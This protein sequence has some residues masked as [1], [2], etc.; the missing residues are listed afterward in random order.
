MLDRLVRALYGEDASDV[1]A[2]KMAARYSAERACLLDTA[3]HAIREAEAIL[4]IDSPSFTLRSL[5]PPRRQLEPV[6]K[7]AEW[8]TPLSGIPGSGPLFGGL[9]AGIGD[10]D[11]VS[12]LGTGFG[13]LLGQSAGGA[14]G[15]M[16][17]P[18][19]GRAIA[20]LVGEKPQAGEEWGRA[21][22]MLGGTALGGA[23]GG[24]VGR[25]QTRP[26]ATTPQMQP[27]APQ[28]Q[29]RQAEYKLARIHGSDLLSAIPGG[30]SLLG[31]VS[32]G[33]Q[34]GA[35][36]GFGTFGGS[37]LGQ[38]LGLVGGATL[39]HALGGTAGGSLGALA[40]TMAGGGFGGHYGRKWTQGPMAN[41]R[42]VIHDKLSSEKRA[43]PMLSL[44]S[45][46][47]APAAIGA[48]GAYAASPQDP[49]A[50]MRN[51]LTGAGLGGG[52]GLLHALHKS[53]S[54]NPELASRL[55]QGL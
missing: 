36:P 31:G 23:L 39:G 1:L 5:P 26:Q 29:E 13:S 34:D 6:E 19:A 38:G 46:A 4:G 53:F 11:A 37:L 20:K 45:R 47:V 21:L 8:S 35:K 51:S 54:A 42:D 41:M 15:G 48:L 52:L 16:V 7:F 25:R 18:H 43:N 24:Y 10:R 2:V 44:L 9:A 33:S 14:L 55:M 40:G 32:A 30:G 3:E 12:G 17:G 50:E 28:A 49:D 22:G 27:A